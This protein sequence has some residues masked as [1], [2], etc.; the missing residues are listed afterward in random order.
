MTLTGCDPTFQP[1]TS[2]IPGE[3]NFVPFNPSGFDCDDNDDRRF[4]TAQE[5][6]DGVDNDCDALVDIDA[7]DVTRAVCD[8]PTLVHPDGRQ[9]FYSDTRKRIGAARNYCDVRG[10][11]L[12]WI[13]DEDTETFLM[14]ELDGVLLADPSLD[15][16]DYFGLWFGFG[17]F[18]CSTGASAT[19]DP[20]WAWADVFAPGQP[21]LSIDRTEPYVQ[22][23]WS[24]SIVIGTEPFLSNLPAQ[25]HPT[26]SATGVTGTRYSFICELRP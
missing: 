20:D 21:C 26:W 8:T 25:P 24:T 6:C 9:F 7:Q 12:A 1:P 11:R 14:D 13:P 2:T 18:L 4:P 10:Y 16:G 5:Q 17:R 15:P 23:R 19:T 3:D 22:A